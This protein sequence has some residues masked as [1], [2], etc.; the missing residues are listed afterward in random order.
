MVVTLC[1]S[2]LQGRPLQQEARCLWGSCHPGSHAGWGFE[3]PI[4]SQVNRQI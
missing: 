2:V 1:V 3:L 4:G